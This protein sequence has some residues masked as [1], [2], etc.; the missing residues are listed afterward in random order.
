MIMKVKWLAVGL[1]CS[2]CQS[3]GE[4][5]HGFLKMFRLTLTMPLFINSLPLLYEIAVI[6]IIPILQIRKLRFRKLGSLS[7][8][9]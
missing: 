6:N 2:P 7:G 8:V 3:E 1:A 9:T 4:N 5:Q